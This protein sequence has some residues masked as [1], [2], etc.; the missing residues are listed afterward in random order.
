MLHKNR[1]KIC[2]PPAYGCDRSSVEREAS[3]LAQ[4]LFT[5]FFC[6]PTPP[7]HTHDPTIYV[8]SLGHRGGESD[9]LTRKMV[10]TFSRNYVRVV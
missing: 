10:I 1:K 3:T 4:Y 5:S 6:L 8:D 2:T 9:C 7:G